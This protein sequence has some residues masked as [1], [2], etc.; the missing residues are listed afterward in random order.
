MIWTEHQGMA[1]LPLLEGG[2][3]GHAYANNNV[4][5]IAGWSD[6]FTS[7]HAVMWQGGRIQRL[8]G[9]KES[10]A[11]SEA[12]A[13]NNS[14]TVVGISNVI[15]E[16]FL[17]FTLS[18][19]NRT[20]SMYTHAFMWR[21]GNSR[22]LGSPFGYRSSYATAI[23]EANEVAG[24]AVRSTEDRYTRAFLWKNGKMQLLDVPLE[25]AS[26]ANGI[27]SRGQ[28]VGYAGS[29]YEQASPFAF[30]TRAVL[31]ENGGVLDL[32]NMIP[33][34]SGWLLTEAYGINDAGQ[35][36][37]AGRYKNARRAFLLTPK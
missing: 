34:D 6:S 26:R 28:I 4:G 16:G 10:R 27:N 23:S 21:N 37:G 19:G 12:Y 9:E 20:D 15:P 2:R 13:I 35:I 30:K 11:A 32:N 25:Q 18:A 22:N 7:R 36:V 5:Q 31:W 24:Y 3:D 29:F 33:Q 1:E 17:P 8:D 14:G